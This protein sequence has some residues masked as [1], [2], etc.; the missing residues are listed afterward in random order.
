MTLND[1]VCLRVSVPGYKAFSRR[2]HS[3]SEVPIIS[4]PP[5]SCNLIVWPSSAARISSLRP[6]LVLSNK[7]RSTDARLEVLVSW[8]ILVV[9]AWRNIVGEA[10]PVVGV[11]EVHVEQSLVG[12]I[13]R[14][15]ALSHGM[16]CP[17]VAHVWFQHHETGVEEVWPADIWC[18]REWS[19]EIKKLI[20]CSPSYHIGIHVDYAAE[21]SLL[22]ELNLC[23]G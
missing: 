9:S 13:K 20:W 23:K 5:P 15:S 14:D 10:D 18:G 3:L 8:H 7:V 17:V 12:A 22:P 1:W 11:L 2:T 21:L 4:G 6:W 16:K 19:L